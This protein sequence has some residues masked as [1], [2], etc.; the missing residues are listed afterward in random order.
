MEGWKTTGWSAVCGL[1]VVSFLGLVA[2]EIE[3]VDRTLAQHSE[4]AA[5][6]FDRR[7]GD[8]PPTD[9]E[10]STRVT[11]ASRTN[12]RNSGTAARS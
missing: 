1:G 6:A 9:G 2:C 11:R 4:K 8:D 10:P 7:A 3:R 12:G 5:E